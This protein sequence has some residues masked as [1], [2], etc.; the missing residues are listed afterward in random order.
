MRT[1]TPALAIGLVSLL[2]ASACGGSGGHKSTASTS[3]SSTAVSRG[4][5]NDRP[6]PPP[7]RP[8]HPSW[9]TRARPAPHSEYVRP[10]TLWPKARGPTADPPKAVSEYRRGGEPFGDAD[11]PHGVIPY[12]P[13]QTSIYDWDAGAGTWKRT[14]NGTRH[15]TT[16]GAQIAPQNLVIQFVSLHN[17]DYVDQSGTKVVESTV[18]GK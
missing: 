6:P 10:E 18:I 11:A 8:P 2:A 4:S 17:L 14:S 3:P 12:S 1:R 16:S 13:R 7:T 9:A 15:T 5:V